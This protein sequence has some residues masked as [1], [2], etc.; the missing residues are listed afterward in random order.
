MCSANGSRR[1]AFF[2]PAATEAVNLLLSG[3]GA[4]AVV[5]PT[6]T[7]PTLP[8]GVAAV[9]PGA[10]ARIFDLVGEI[11]EADAYTDTIGQDLKVIGPEDAATHTAPG[12]KLKV[13]QGAGCECVRIGF[14]KYGHMGVHIESQRGGVE[15]HRDRHGESLHG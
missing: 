9:P 7:A 15:I 11:K 1:C 5:L 12:M 10:L 3:E 6:F 14:V 2:N 4:S 8:A 13:E